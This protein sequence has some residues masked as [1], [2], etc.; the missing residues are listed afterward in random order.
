MSTVEF[1]DE[2]LLSVPDSL[3]NEAIR[4]YHLVGFFILCWYTEIYKS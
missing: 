2:R 1:N 4:Y 3:S